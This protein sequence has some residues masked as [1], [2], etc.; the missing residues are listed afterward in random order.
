M[1]DVKGDG[2]HSEEPGCPMFT[3]YNECVKII[4]GVGK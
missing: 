3:S 4:Q 1:E 2:E